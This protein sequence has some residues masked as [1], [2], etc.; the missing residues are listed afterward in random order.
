MLYKLVCTSINVEKALFYIIIENFENNLLNF[1]G[2]K[3][4][5]LWIHDNGILTHDKG[6]NM[7]I[8]YCIHR[9]FIGQCHKWYE[10]NIMIYS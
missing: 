9:C 7:N 8:C 4:P 6:A 10:V 1:C 3:T 2:I 5:Q